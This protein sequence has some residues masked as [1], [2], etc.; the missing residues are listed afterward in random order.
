[1]R[2][3]VAL[4]LASAAAATTASAL[5]VRAPGLAPVSTF[6]RIADRKAR[7]VA[8]YG[9]MYRVIS[10]PRCMNCHPA[11]PVPTAGDRMAPHNPRIWSDADGHGV[12]GLHCNACHQL[13]NSKAWGVNVKSVPGN[14]KWG[15]AP[16]EM[17]W[18]GKT[19]GEICRQI[20]D[21]S[22]NGG[23]DLEALHE[24]MA[25][26]I[27]VGWGWSPGEGRKPAP[28]TQ[29]QFGALARAWID[30]GAECPA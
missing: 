13:E 3:I 21:K 12:A 25:T 20:K 18:Q 27:L 1:M 26:D 29:E 16:P 4:V 28:G 11:T 19:P 22:R 17:A 14:P 24:H 9:E 8:L 2:T 23:R 30:T 6:E 10:S 7:S 5:T 15:L